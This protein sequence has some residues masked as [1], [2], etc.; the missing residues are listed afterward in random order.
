[1]WQAQQLAVAAK[2]R[3]DEARE[4]HL[5]RGGEVATAALERRP[6]PQ[7]VTLTRTLP[8]AVSLL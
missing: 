7:P 5:A 4:G 2:A 3:V 6:Q 1:M 8:L